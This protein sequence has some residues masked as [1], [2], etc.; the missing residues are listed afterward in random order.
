MDNIKVLLLGKT[1]EIR[2]KIEEMFYSVDY[3]M[4]TGTVATEQEAMEILSGN[5]ID[6]ILID[7]NIEEDIYD[8]ADRISSEYAEAAIIIL[9]DSLLEENMHKAFLTG[10]KDILI[11]P[12]NPSVLFDSIYKANEQMKKK[13]VMRRENSAKNSKKPGRGKVITV[14]SAKGGAGKTFIAANL[15][16]ALAKSK[17][18]RVVLVDLDLDYGNAALAFNIIPRFTIL[19]IVDDIRNIDHEFIESYLTLTPSGIW[20]LPSG[21]KLMTNEF[22]NMNHIEIILKTLQNAFDYIIVDMPGR[23]QDMENPAFILADYLF[24]V[25]TPEI[26]AIRNVKASL[27]ILSERN[28]PK[29]KIKIILNRAG[30]NEIRNR[31]IETTLNYSVYAHVNAD[32]KR[33]AST[34]NVGIPFVQKYPHSTLSKN[35]NYLAKKIVNPS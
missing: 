3:I 28:Y 32:S 2:S 12:M 1:G 34:M 25:V 5:M 7:S 14:Y 19:D 17:N 23:T 8:I 18:K 22:I 15:A 27:G 29:S 26:A 6:V 13:I 21:A 33:V 4:L 16:V 30:G 11:K 35:F 10:V 31:D 24:M 9:E 20:V